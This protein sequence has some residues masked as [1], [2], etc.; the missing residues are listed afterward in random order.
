MAKAVGTV[1]PRSAAEIEQLARTVRQGLG[2][3]YGDRISVLPIL[4]FALDEMF[5]DGHLAVL[6][7]GDMGGAEGRTEW[8]RPVITLAASTYAALKRGDHRARMTAAHEL[9]HLLMHTQRPV[10]NFKAPNRD[11]RYDPEWQADTFAG[12]LLM[13]R[14]AFLKTR[15]IVEARER[16]GVSMGAVMVRAK[17]LGHKFED[18]PRPSVRFKKKG[19]GKRRAP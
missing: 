19:H 17:K 2:I 14:D 15:T 10:Y 9:G 6:S 3:G 5:V 4:E 12:A 11:K 16:F 18:D 13:P 1:R 7:D 8:A